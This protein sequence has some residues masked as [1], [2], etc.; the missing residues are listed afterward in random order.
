MRQYPLI[1]GAIQLFD[2]CP[3]HSDFLFLYPSFNLYFTYLNILSL[4]L[5]PTVQGKN[6]FFER[7]PTNTILENKFTS[8]YIQ[9]RDVF[10]VSKQ[11]GRSFLCI[12]LWI[13]IYV[14]LWFFLTC[15]LRYWF[16]VQCTCYLLYTFL[17]RNRLF[18]LPYGICLLFIRK[19]N[20]KYMFGFASQILEYKSIHTK[21]VLV[22]GF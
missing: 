18:Y 15:V 19:F 1:N 11:I 10:P 7:V 5:L 9:R 20:P 12:T 14:L 8:I 16:Y 13:S 6:W 17:A 3:F 21:R 2:C 4:Q 22:I